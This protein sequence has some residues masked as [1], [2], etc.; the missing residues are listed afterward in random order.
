ML[1]LLPTMADQCAEQHNCDEIEPELWIAHQRQM[2]VG[3]VGVV[4]ALQ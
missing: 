4:Q 2:E 3:W 1:G